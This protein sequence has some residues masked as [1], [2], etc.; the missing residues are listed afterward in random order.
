MKTLRH[1]LEKLRKIKRHKYHPIIHKIKHEHGLSHKTLL[2][3][4]EYGPHSN[5]PKTIVRESIKILLLA[6]ILSSLGGLALENIKTVFVSIVPIIIL[7]PTLNNL[8]GDFGII[9]SSRFIT[10]LYQ[11][12]LKGKWYKNSG[13]KKLFAQVLIIALL[14][15]ILSF[16]ASLVISFFSGYEF[17][18]SVAFKILGL[19]LADIIIMVSV[20]FL[21]SITAGIYFYKKKEDP[22][23]FLIPITTS[24][25]DFGNM[26]ILAIL[27][28]LF[29]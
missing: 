3:V 14:T 12:K 19:S 21:I 7:M 23:N 22:A 18:Y 13:V 15:G 29:F 1:K 10:F 5:V 8:I 9:I 20:L 25:A 17:D 11:D 6:S 27:I 28:T 24:M 2:Y 4:K 26:V 16:A